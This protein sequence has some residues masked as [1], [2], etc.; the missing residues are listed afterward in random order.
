MRQT[1]VLKRLDIFTKLFYNYLDKFARMSVKVEKTRNKTE[2][3]RGGIILEVAVL[4]L[5]GVIITG[6]LTYVCENYLYTDSVKAQTED[7]A[8]EIASE[9]RLALAE[10]PSYE[11]LVKYWYH[12]ADELDIIYDVDFSCDKVTEEKCR[13]FSDRHPGL[14]IRYV[15][16]DEFADLPDEDKKLYAEI[17][18]TWLISRIDQIKQT[19]HVDF[20]FCVISEEPYDRQFFLFSGA[21]P[22]AVRGTNYEEV[23]PLGNTVTVSDSQA[24]AMAE[25][26]KNSSHL[27]DAGRYV[28]YYKHILSF[29][30]HGVFIGLTYDLSVLLSYVDTQTKSGATLAIVNQLVLSLTCLSLIFVFVLLPI[31]KLQ[32]NIRLYKE[33]KD[34]GMVIEGLSEIYSR[35]E[36]GRLA[37][38]TSDMIREIEA[39]I[40]KIGAINAE[41]ERISTELNLASRIQ[42]AMLPNVFP[43]FPD[44]TEF[45]IFACM[46]P[47]KEVG[48]DFYDFFLIDDDHLGLVIADVSGK[49]VPAALFMMISK[50]LVN[51]YAVNGF[52]PAKTLE[53]VN[54]QVCA[55]NKAEMFVTVWFGVLEISSGKLTAANAGHEYPVVKRADGRFELFKDKHGFV[56]GGMDGV[57][58]K[59]YEL[60][61]TPGSAVFLYTDGVPEA[62]DAD[63]NMFG[64]DKMLDALNGCGGE[65]PDALIKCVRE[66]VDAFVKD[67]EQ[68]DDLTMLCVEYKGKNENA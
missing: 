12:H 28:D 47:A 56:I 41:K 25:A 37:D 16:D 42:E 48:G 14:Q 59:E 32:N 50:I 34:S 65:A 18:Y 39:H 33:T 30:G 8:D 64:T 26:T 62:A 35:N 11:S 21:D 60:F 38:D 29:D 52:S 57:S 53:A 15:S 9:S 51:N 10:F 1:A 23:Y 66:A 54:R 68:F 45:D 63:G 58:Y 67:A 4:F 31:K 27:A 20:L 17:V 24:F 13:V 44:R 36:I 19:Y 2:K 55:N 7:H 22:G 40:E 46:D 61:L 43:P 6:V 3:R 49:S 5:V